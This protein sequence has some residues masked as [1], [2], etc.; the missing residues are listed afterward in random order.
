MT[1][2]NLL[3][4]IHTFGDDCFD[5]F[6]PPE[7]RA[8]SSVHWTPVFVARQ[9]AEFLVHRPGTRVLD[10]GCGPGKFCIIGALMTEG[11]FTGIEQRKHLCDVARSVIRQTRLPH[12]EIVHGNVTETA[13]SNFDAFYLFNPFVENMETV[14][15]IDATVSLSV[16]LYD[17]Y[18]E[19]VARQLALAPLG[20]RLA[21]YC[22][23]C[24]EVPLGYT[25]LET[26]PGQD[27]DLKFW[28]KTKNYPVRTSPTDTMPA[29]NKCRSIY[30]LV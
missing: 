8:L 25:Q 4:Y 17:K 21:T 24:A 1:T 15:K 22:G 3:N 9:A 27:P 20:T 11:K 5:L 28:E 12:V 30:D 7:I 18:T 29:I 19:Y 14:L 13:F 2:L 6:Y 23:V 16:D 10:I 26:F